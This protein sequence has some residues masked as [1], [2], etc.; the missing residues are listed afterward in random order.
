[1]VELLEYII[2][3]KKKPNAKFSKYSCQISKLTLDIVRLIYFPLKINLLTTTKKQ[4]IFFST[5]IKCCL[6]FQIQAQFIL[7]LVQTF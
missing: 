1:M 4:T 6:S 7:N 5:F 2:L 3:K